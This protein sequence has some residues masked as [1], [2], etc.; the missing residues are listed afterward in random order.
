MSS[1]LCVGTYSDSFI[2]C[3]V[4]P[5]VPNTEYMPISPVLSIV[6]ICPYLLPVYCRHYWRRHML[7]AGFEW[8]APGRFTLWVTLCMHLSDATTNGFCRTSL[9]GPAFAAACADALFPAETADVLGRPGRLIRNA[10]G[11]N[12]I[13]MWHAIIW[14]DEWW[15]IIS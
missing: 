11:L 8:F 15:Y 3:Y 12:Y 4:P 1:I 14:Y 6:K 10:S 7:G 5:E 13:L 2:E 9:S